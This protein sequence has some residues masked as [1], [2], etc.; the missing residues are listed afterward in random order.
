MIR[1]ENF[2]I[3]GCII[4]YVV[5]VPLM[6]YFIYLDMPDRH[7][8]LASAIFSTVLSMVFSLF[9]ALLVSPLFVLVLSVGC[10]TAVIPKVLRRGVHRLSERLHR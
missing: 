9:S 7:H 4:A 8:W 10:A 1:E 2:G 6:A 5:S 3:V